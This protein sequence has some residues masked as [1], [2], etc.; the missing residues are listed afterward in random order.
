M[1]NSGKLK[2][3][4]PRLDFALTVAIILA[5]VILGVQMVRRYYLNPPQPLRIG[6]KAAIEGVDANGYD[7]VLILAYSSDCTYCS[8]SAPVYR[9]LIK[10]LSGAKQVRKIA[11]L[12]QRLEESKPY[13]QQLG[14]VVDDIRQT[15]LHKLGINWVPTLVVIDRNGMVSH[16][17]T[18]NIP[19]EEQFALLDETG[20]EYRNRLPTDDSG[21]TL[22]D[23]CILSSLVQDRSEVMVLDTRDREQYQKEHFSPSINIPVD[24]LETRAADEL[25]PGATLIVIGTDRKSTLVAGDWL[26]LSHHSKPVGIVEKRSPS[27]QLA[28]CK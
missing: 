15:N 3:S 12:P 14:L 7:R 6:S 27:K 25:P 11:L 19:I 24:E 1:L 21:P 5:G 16:M 26:M 9:R 18:G 20:V 22:I 2:Q 8:K 28:G 23:V 13:L 4:L 17:W 10:L